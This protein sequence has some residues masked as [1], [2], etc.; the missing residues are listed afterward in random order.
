M[1]VITE[2]A[3]KPLTATV[4]DVAAIVDVH[5]IGNPVAV[6]NV[7]VWGAPQ[8]PIVPELCRYLMAGVL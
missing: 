8:V 7:N 2:P 3:G 5:V 4:A 6:L 1:F